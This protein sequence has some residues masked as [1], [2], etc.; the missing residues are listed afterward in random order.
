MLIFKEGDIHSDIIFSF[1]GRIEK[2][3]LLCGQISYKQTW[4]AVRIEPPH[5]YF[6]TL[7][8]NMRDR[9]IFSNKCL[10]FVSA[11]PFCWGVPTHEF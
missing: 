2:I 7:V 10:F 11:I 3:S 5:K 1:V 6:G 9:T 8:V 4:Q